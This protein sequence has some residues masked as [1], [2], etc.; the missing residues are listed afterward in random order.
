MLFN[1]VTLIVKGRRQ[2]R[3]VT[4]RCPPNTACQ[5]SFYKEQGHSLFYKIYII[6]NFLLSKSQQYYKF[7]KQ[8][9][10]SNVFLMY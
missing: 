1:Y 6:Y 9:H 5:V 8:T 10:N 4:Y 2:D 3:L 7:T